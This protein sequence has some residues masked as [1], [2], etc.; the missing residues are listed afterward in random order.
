MMGR[1]TLALAVIL[2]VWGI[3]SPRKAACQER[4]PTDH[5]WIVGTWR[6]TKLEYGEFGEWKGAKQM[7]LVATSPRDIGLFLIDADGKRSR[8]GDSE[9]C[10]L[11]EK[12]LFF[13][14]VGSGLW[15]DYRRPSKDELIL[16]LKSGSIHAELRREKK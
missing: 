11:D 2:V 6:S 14:P 5:E 8:A 9:P 13:G 16:D 10:L 15:F 3:A 12:K 7:E 4:K 1:L